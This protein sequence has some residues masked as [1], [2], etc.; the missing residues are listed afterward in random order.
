M[1]KARE[2]AF[3]YDL[4]ITSDWRDRFDTLINENI[5]IP[6][7]SQ[8]LDVNCGTGAHSIELAE[9]ARGKGEVVGIDPGAERVDLARA[10]ALAKKL[11]RV[12]FQQG[13]TTVL[14]FPDDRFDIVIGE[15][16]MLSPGDI[17]GVLTE[18]VRVARPEGR[19]V[20]K[21]TT[22]GSFDEFFSIYWE[23]LMS[24]GL[25]DDV[26]TALEQLINERRT[27]SD[28]EM[29]T[30]QAGLRNVKSVSSSE[31]FGFE[32][33]EAF[34]TSPLIEDVFLADWMA[35]VPELRRQEVRERIVSIIDRERYGAAFE[36]SIKATL[37]TGTK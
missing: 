34:L 18:M 22:R 26:W 11:D 31:E 16:S 3:R 28:S 15:A 37:L 10:K 36:V 7:E 5:E 25:V 6:F 27:I 32:T 14:P 8:V 9:R 30:R 4:F 2:L 13:I 24:A 35:I 19:I 29:M 12:T 33:G 20:L 21:M 17:N 23:V 1:S